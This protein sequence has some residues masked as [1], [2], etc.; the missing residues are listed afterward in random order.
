VG[1]PEVT[2]RPTG[3]ARLR[4]GLGE[5]LDLGIVGG[6]GPQRSFVAG[7]ELKWRFAHLAPAGAGPGAP[8][9]NAALISGVGVGSA[10]YPYEDMPPP[11]H[12]YVAPYTGV[13]A[14]GGIEVVQMLVGLR[15]AAS[16]TFGN[17]VTDLT[18]YPVLAFGVQLRPSRA[19]SLFAEGDL[20]GGITT[21][22]SNDTA[23][24]GYV[25]AGLSYTFD[26]LWSPPK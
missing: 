11:R 18:L 12:L 13:L 22:D 7:P 23:V 17:S 2:A 6:V 15:F 10:Q 16:E 8:R 5:N 3:A 19:F 1:D 21:R 20:A 14:S 4:L 9:F 25:T 26:G 24:I